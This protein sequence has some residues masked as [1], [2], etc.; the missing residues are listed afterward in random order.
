MSESTSEAYVYGP[1]PYGLTESDHRGIVVTMSILFILYTLMVFGIRL[2][3]RHVNMGVDDW[4]A[5]VATVCRLFF[6]NLDAVSL[7]A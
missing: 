7:H 4:L 3:T 2:A 1:R 5:V 6:H